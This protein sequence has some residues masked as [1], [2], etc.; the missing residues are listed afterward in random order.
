MRA[1]HSGIVASVCA[2]LVAS[3]I[4]ATG[5]RQAAG[6]AVR[7][8]ADDVGGVVTGAKGPEAGVWVIAETLDLPT[9]FVR[10]VVTDDN[11]RYLLPERGDAKPAAAPTLPSSSSSSSGDSALHAKI[12]KLEEEITE[13]KMLVAL[14]EEQDSPS[15]I[16]H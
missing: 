3:S 13:L 5:A 15:Q 16:D 12:R 8:D 6:D 4:A 9:R 7:I 11:G 1:M 10:I 2:L 14:Y